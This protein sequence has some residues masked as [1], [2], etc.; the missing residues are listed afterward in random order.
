MFISLRVA[1]TRTNRLLQLGNTAVKQNHSHV[2]DS[3]PA[4]TETCSLNVQLQTADERRGKTLSHRTEVRL[5]NGSTGCRRLEVSLKRSKMTVG[6][7]K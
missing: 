4:L 5:F 7:I 2:K 6:I 3:C 1:Q